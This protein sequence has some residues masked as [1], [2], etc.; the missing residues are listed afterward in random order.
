[1]KG[2]RVPLAVVLGILTFG[3]GVIVEGGVL[4]PNPPLVIA[5]V[6]FLYL[7]IS[8]FLVAKKGANLWDNWATLLGMTVPLVALYIM[9]VAA[10]RGA[11]ELQR[12]EL[13]FFLPGCLGILIGV[14]AA[15]AW[16]TKRK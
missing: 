16:K 7:A 13:I 15:G 5:S 2:M 9:T 8:Q 6:M 3:V 12:Q 10:K 1:M 4:H 11:A 14:L